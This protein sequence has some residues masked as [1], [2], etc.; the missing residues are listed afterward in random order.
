M[1]VGSPTSRL[2]SADQRNSWRVA[3]PGV[4]SPAVERPQENPAR[5]IM[6]TLWD[7]PRWLEAYHLYDE[8]GSDLFEEICRL[9]EYYLTRT[10][11][12]I[13]QREAP[14][15][16]AA[17]AVEAI[18][19]LGAGSSKKTTHLLGEQVRQRGGGIFAPIDVSLP[20]LVTS[21]SFVQ[22]NY[23]ELEFHGLHALYEDGFSTVD[24]SLPTLFVFLGS[25]VG[26]FNHTDFPRFFR[27][28]S[29]AMGPND[30]LLLGADR[31]KSVDVLEKAYD[32]ARG[33]TAEFILNVFR[34]VNR[35]LGSNFDIGKMRYRSRYN[36]EWQQI[37]MHAV[38]NVTQEIDFPSYRSSFRWEK[39]EQI[40]V[41]ISRKFDPIRLQQQ[42]RYFELEPVAHYTD[43]QE[44]FSLL[45]F[46]KSA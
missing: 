15:I 36:P 32:D 28:L 22:E 18:V 44:W 39:D 45:L 13:L 5:S 27:R 34:N 6:T 8:R 24:K 43:P 33:L 1:T 16:I 41:E 38:A 30:F 26:N 3:T 37:E 12:A 25:T 10:E 31:V 40:L 11:N 35:L 2:F 23:P 21:R 14:R 4:W 42:L 29:R 7:Q 46:K 17:A 20:G 19:E 9:P